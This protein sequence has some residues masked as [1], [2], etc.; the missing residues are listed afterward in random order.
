M[1]QIYDGRESF[2]QWD[3]NVKVTATSLTVGDEIHC[4]NAHQ[5][6]A[7]VVKAYALDG[8]VVADV[9]NILLQT[10][11]PIRIYRYV[12]TSDSS[13]TVDEK[14]FMVKQR[15]RPSDYIYTETDFVTVQRAVDEAIEKA[16]QE[17]DFKGEPG[18]TPHIG[19]NGNWF[20]GETDTGARASGEN[21]KAGED[22]YTPQ[23]GIDY[24]TDAD[25]S[26]MVQSVLFAL[27]DGDEVSY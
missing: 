13:Q 16:K 27:P 9:P 11:L 22:G 25:K 5:P 21:G 1:I 19:E 7:L 14:T 17:G 24:F 26:E 3:L 12:R 2:W 4:T 10:S 8:K 20:I 15:Q 23:K 18:T 6:I